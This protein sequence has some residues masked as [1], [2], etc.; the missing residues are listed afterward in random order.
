MFTRVGTKVLKPFALTIHLVPQGANLIQTKIH[1]LQLV[2]QPRANVVC[3][4]F[5]Q[6]FWKLSDLTH[7]GRGNTSIYLCL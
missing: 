5:P 3:S 7:C 4:Y 2:V 6:Y 1:Y